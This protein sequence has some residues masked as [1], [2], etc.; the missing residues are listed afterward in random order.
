MTAQRSLVANQSARYI[1]HKPKP[2]N[3]IIYLFIY[4]LTYIFIYLF[5]YFFGWTTDSAYYEKTRSTRLLA[6]IGPSLHLVYV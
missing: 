1:G 2:Y 3:N 4:L 5:I 6:D